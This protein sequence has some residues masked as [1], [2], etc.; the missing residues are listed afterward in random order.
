MTIQFSR[1]ARIV[2]LTEKIV[3]DLLARSK[4]GSIRGTWDTYTPP[5]F[6]Q[7]LPEDDEVIMEHLREHI[8]QSPFVLGMY[9]VYSRPGPYHSTFFSHTLI[10]E[11]LK[12]LGGWNFLPVEFVPSGRKLKMTVTAEFYPKLFGKAAEFPFASDEERTISFEQPPHDETFVC[13]SVAAW[14]EKRKEELAAAAWNSKPVSYLVYAGTSLRQ[15]LALLCSDPYRK[16]SIT[17]MADM[18]IYPAIVQEG[19]HMAANAVLFELPLKPGESLDDLYED[20]ERL[21]ARVRETFRD[22]GIELPPLDRHLFAWERYV[23]EE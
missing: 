6:F 1:V 10:T 3:A 22:R 2:P 20:S 16:G 15:G 4:T 14:Y 21:L 23:P 18:R 8:A 13:E 17:V 11:Y 12:G 9:E 7:K 19:M 5:G